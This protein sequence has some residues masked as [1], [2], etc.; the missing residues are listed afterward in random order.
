MEH[1]HELIGIQLPPQS[2]DEHTNHKKTLMVDEIQFSKDQ[3]INARRQW[4]TRMDVEI[5]ERSVKNGT[6]FITH[7]LH[8]T[9]DDSRSLSVRVRQF[10]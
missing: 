6:K 4:T 10:G 5:A 9:S 7:Q 3:I 1:Q 8:L 2:S